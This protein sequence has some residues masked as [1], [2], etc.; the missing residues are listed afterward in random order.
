MKVKLETLKFTTVNVIVKYKSAAM[1]MSKTIRT[2]IPVVCTFFSMSA[3]LTSCGGGGDNT[4]ENW[5]LAI[6]LILACLKRG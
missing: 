3:L 5:I 2:A 6:I 1:K 4:V